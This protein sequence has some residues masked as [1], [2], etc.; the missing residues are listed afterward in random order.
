MGMVM[1]DLISFVAV[2]EEASLTRAATTLCV[3][4]SAISK[5]IRRLK[6]TLGAAVTS[7]AIL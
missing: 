2:I 3:T 4:Q 6:G 1:D 7:S 5:R